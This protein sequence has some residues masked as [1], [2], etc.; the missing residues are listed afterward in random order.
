M[1]DYQKFSAINKQRAM[2]WHKGGLDEWSV[3]DW[4]NA[5][6][7]EAGELCNAVK[8]FRRVQDQIQGHD[9][10]TPQPRDLSQAICAIGKEIGDCYAYLDLLAQ[11][12]GL[13]MWPCVATTFDQ[14]SQR[15]GFPE[16]AP[17]L[18]IDDKLV[19][20][21]AAAQSIVEDRDFRV[22]SNNVTERAIETIIRTAT[23]EP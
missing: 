13:E 7:G 20:I 23:V 4:S 11:R 1:N 10:D 22:H 15:E 19:V 21:R 17:V 14:I 3:T 16:R 6:A 8:K 9:G 12:F 5:F 18:G 2:R